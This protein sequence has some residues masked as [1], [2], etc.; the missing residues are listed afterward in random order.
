[1]AARTEYIRASA[2]P[3]KTGSRHPYR[4]AKI[5]TMPNPTVLFD[6]P[7]E[8]LLQ[9]TKELPRRSVFN[10]MRTSRLAQGI[11]HE[12]LYHLSLQRKRGVFIWAGQNAQEQTMLYLL[13]DILAAIPTNP[14]VGLEALG[15][16]ATGGCNRVL[17]R[18]LQAGV[19]PNTRHNGS[20]ALLQ[21]STGRFPACTES[22]RIL[23]ANG[24]STGAVDDTRGRS[25]LHWAAS[26]GNSNIITVLLH[27]GMDINIRS[28]W[29]NETPLI[30]AAQRA[31]YRAAA[32]L[33][34]AGANTSLPDYFGHTPLEHAA[35][36]SILSLV[37]LLVN[38]GANVDWQSLD[39]RT[40]LS[41][42]VEHG[43]IHIVEFLV[44]SGCDVN[45]PDTYGKTPICRC[46]GNWFPWSKVQGIIRNSP[47]Y[48]G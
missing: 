29:A 21:A 30:L 39:G 4:R 27:A 42:A 37:Q 48:R 3:W 24:A 23:L 44:N 31:H 46:K 10:F 40:P 47:G 5:L 36:N 20:H 43:S 17:R 13:D 19:N 1:M 7:N 32:V 18:L 33:V 25:A 38:N 6:L 35:N 15:A 9:I 41:F 26:A 2:P 22:V 12:I 28:S 45:L 16:A 34:A 8:L 11:G 14:E